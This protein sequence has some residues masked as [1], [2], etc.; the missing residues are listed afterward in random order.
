MP[1]NKP[2]SQPTSW[3]WAIRSSAS[4]GRSFSANGSDSRSSSAT[5]SGASPSSS[6]LMELWWISF[7]RALLFSSRGAALTSSSSCLIMLPIRM[8]LAGCSTISV[9]GRSPPSAL[10]S[11]AMAMPS[12]PTTRIWGSWVPWFIPSLIPLVCPIAPA[13]DAYGAGSIRGRIT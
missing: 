1:W 3:A 13:A 11:P 8:T 2:S 4:L 7:S 9:T 5:S 10:S 12:G 6:S